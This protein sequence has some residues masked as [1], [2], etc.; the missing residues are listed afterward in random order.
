M[1]GG[2]EIGGGDVAGVGDGGQPNRV[3]HR[4][5]RLPPLLHHGEGSRL[6]LCLRP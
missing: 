4:R 2:R 5:E 1:E 6:K 3:H